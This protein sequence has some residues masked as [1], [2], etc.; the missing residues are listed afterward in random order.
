MSDIGHLMG[1]ML[2]KREIFVA[3]DKAMLTNAK[4]LVSEFGI[5]EKSPD[6]ALTHRIPK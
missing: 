3:R 5:S 6:E 4:V 1:H 2:S